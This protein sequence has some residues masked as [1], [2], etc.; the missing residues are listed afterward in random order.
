MRQYQ[1]VRK[2][3]R[4]AG[5]QQLRP[6]R[7]LRQP[8]RMK[9]YNLGKPGFIADD[10]AMRLALAGRRLMPDHLHPQCCNRARRS[11]AYFRHLPAI[12]KI[13]RQMKQHI[14][15]RIAAHQLGEQGG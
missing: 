15:D 4:L 6:D 12:H 5:Y 7:K 9:Q 2:P 3:L 14:P 8:R 11:L 13:H 10:H 1:T